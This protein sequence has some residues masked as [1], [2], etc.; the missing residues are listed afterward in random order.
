MSIFFQWL[1]QNWHSRLQET[2]AIV[3]LDIPV[4]TI[5]IDL[6]KRFNALVSLNLGFTFSLFLP[7]LLYNFVYLL[8]VPLYKKFFLLY[9]AIFFSL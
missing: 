3:I 4:R 8:Y 1:V 6:P 9:F 5:A 7:H 2:E